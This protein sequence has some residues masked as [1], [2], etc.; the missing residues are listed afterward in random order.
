MHFPFQT[1]L[2]I[3][4]VYGQKY[5]RR[6]NTWGD[7]DGGHI[8]WEGEVAYHASRYPR[9]HPLKCFRR[10]CK[11][12]Y[13][14]TQT[15]KCIH[16]YMYIYMCCAYVMYT[17][18]IDACIHIYVYI[19]VNILDKPVFTYTCLCIYIY[20]EVYRSWCYFNSTPTSLDTG[21]KDQKRLPPQG[22]IITAGQCRPLAKTVRFNVL[23]AGVELIST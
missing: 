14:Y 16:T 2:V 20:M 10:S 1:G 21:P 13:M 23:K 22:D 5:L 3:H 8:S 18:I 12:S 11:I 7:G 6:K 19:H 17:Y 4:L 9:L 15:Q